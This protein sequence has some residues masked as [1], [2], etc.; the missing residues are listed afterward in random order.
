MSLKVISTFF[1]S[2]KTGKPM[3]Y[4][5]AGENVILDIVQIRTITSALDN[6][7]VKVTASGKGHVARNRVLLAFEA[8]AEAIADVLFEGGKDGGELFNLYKAHKNPLTFKKIR[9]GLGKCCYVR[10]SLS[11]CIFATSHCGIKIKF[12]YLELL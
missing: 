6:C 8:A 3:L 10:A 4:V 1:F 11:F 7:P 5:Y 12:K 9:S 2:Q